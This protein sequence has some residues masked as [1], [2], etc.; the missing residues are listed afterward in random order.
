M[1]YDILV[2]QILIFLMIL[3]IY[4]HSFHFD[5]Q[6]YGVIPKSLYFGNNLNISQDNSTSEFPQIATS[7]N[8]VYVVWE[9]ENEG[10]NGKK[11]IFFTSSLDGGITFGS[12]KN[13]SE[14][15][16]TSEFPQIATSGNK[17]YVVWEEENEGT[18]G[19]KEIYLR[20]S[21]DDG[22]SFKLIRNI[23]RTLTGTS[24]FPQIAASGNNVYVVWVDDT[25]G[26][27]DIYFKASPNS[28]QGFK[29]KK[30]LSE[31]NGTSEFPQIAASGNKVYV[32][33]EDDTSGNKEIYF[34]ASQ[35]TGKIFKNT[36]K[37]S[38]TTGISKFP[39]IDILNNETYVIWQDENTTELQSAKQSNINNENRIV[40]KHAKTDKMLFGS[41]NIL[42]SIG[43]TKSPKLIAGSDYFFG[44]WIAN[45]PNNKSTIEFYPFGYFED[46]SGT[47]IVLDE[48]GVKASNPSMA[49]SGPNLFVVWQDTKLGNSDI[50]FKKIS[51]LDFL[52]HN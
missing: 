21:S 27:K 51:Q 28:G 49:V 16:G 38:N 25:N 41:T 44:T 50:F 48:Q 4:Y 13:L 14:T 18:N 36:K 15:N 46:F 10:T 17:V 47:G 39:D 12:I 8:K 30:N 43:N 29:G 1:I 7:G 37:I 9:E 35:K 6:A 2:L 31:T 19:K 42:E 45:L 24:Q 32:V 34:K 40:F 33:W 23:S 22:S 52:S 11:E 5:G 26:N 20:P 3:I